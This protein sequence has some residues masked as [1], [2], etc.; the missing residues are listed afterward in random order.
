MCTYARFILMKC[1]NLPLHRLVE[2]WNRL[3]KTELYKSSSNNH[4]MKQQKWQIFVWKFGVSCSSAFLWEP[5]DFPWRTWLGQLLGF[6]ACRISYQQRYQNQC[7]TN[8]TDLS[9][10]SSITVT[11]VLAKRH[12][13]HILLKGIY[14]KACA[15]KIHQIESN[16]KFNTN[17]YYCLFQLIKWLT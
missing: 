17:L 16:R 2:Q 13:L 6:A 15:N 8:R 14:R 1:G 12:N 9:D 3:S 10:D 11:V 5:R 4:I 7:T